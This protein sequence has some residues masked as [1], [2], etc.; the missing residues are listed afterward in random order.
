M[1]CDRCKTETN[2]W[3]MSKFNTDS[4]CPKCQEREINHP[5]FVEANRRENEAVQNGDL[6]FPGIGC[7]TELYPSEK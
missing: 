3:M 4:I 2:I 6:N 1:K 7:P 5:N